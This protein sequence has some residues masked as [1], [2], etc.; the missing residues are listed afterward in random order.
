[1][2]TLIF[3]PD[4]ADSVSLLAN[5]LFNCLDSPVQTAEKWPIGL[6][7]FSSLQGLKI[8][9]A[10]EGTTE[11]IIE[12]PSRV[13]LRG[14]INLEKLEDSIVTLPN[15]VD[16]VNPS[17]IANQA[18]AVFTT[19]PITKVKSGHIFVTVGSSGSQSGQQPV[20]MDLYRDYGT[21]SQTHL[22]G[23]WSSAPGGVGSFNWLGRITK[24]D[25]LADD[26]PH[27]YSLVCIG[28]GGSL[29][30]VP[31]SAATL[32]AFELGSPA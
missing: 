32:Q 12:S 2:T 5:L 25:S 9:V 3:G 26:L 7:D 21:P 10:V 6:F 20:Q 19:D 29:I 27:T 28:T 11:I 31:A 15:F 13:I 23:P 18:S 8:T 22:V 30:S 24:I 1:M 16:F 17:P 14:T 4:V